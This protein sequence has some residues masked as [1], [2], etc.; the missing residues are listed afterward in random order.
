MAASTRGMAAL[1]GQRAVCAGPSEKV[2]NLTVR[3]LAVD[4]GMSTTFNAWTFDG[5]LPGPTLEVCVG[6][7]VTINLSNQDTVAH[8]LDTHALTIDA[9]KFGPTSPGTTLTITGTAG[10]PGAFMYHCASA[11][12]T[13]VHIKSGLYGAMIVHRRTPLPPAS[14]E[15]VVV[16]SAV[17]GERSADGVIAGTDSSRTL[18]NDATF[19]FFNGRLEHDALLV[20]AGERVRVY[21]VNVGPGV[22]ALHVIGSMLDAVIDGA[23]TRRN[24]QTYGVAPGSGAIVDF[25]IPEP[26]E[27]LLVDHGQL[28]YV[29]TGLALR[30]TANP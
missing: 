15:L 24:V 21:F 14:R 3:E 27:F 19:R 6:D 12:A 5:R 16:E 30:F 1:R 13:D 18:R 20:S 8:G 26:G 23:D 4:L 7:R 17:F 25:T 10:T 29:P 2:F 28:G 9:R 22:S 11:S